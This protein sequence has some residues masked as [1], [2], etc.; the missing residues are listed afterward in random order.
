VDEGSRTVEFCLLL[1]A[2]AVVGLCFTYSY[3]LFFIW[4]DLWLILTVWCRASSVYVVV[5]CGVLLKRL[6]V[7]SHKQCHVIAQGL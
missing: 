6:N 3:C 5:V 1:A 4:R 7:G 2:E